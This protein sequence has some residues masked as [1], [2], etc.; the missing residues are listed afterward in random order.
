[1]RPTSNRVCVRLCLCVVSGWEVKLYSKLKQNPKTRYRD[2][3]MKIFQFMSGRFHVAASHTK[4]NSSLHFVHSN[5][6]ECKLMHH[7]N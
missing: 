6:A 5:I 7:H 4:S 3:P 1:M 2:T